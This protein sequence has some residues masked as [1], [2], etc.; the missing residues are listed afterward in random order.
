MFLRVAP[1][2]GERKRE[3]ERERERKKNGDDDDE[4]RRGEMISFPNL[5]MASRRTSRA[6]WIY[7]GGGISRHRHQLYRKSI[8]FFLLL[9]LLLLSSLFHYIA[10]EHI[11]GL[12]ISVRLTRF[13]LREHNSITNQTY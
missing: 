10:A 8:E 7:T 11:D 6:E 1:S 9:L 5:M 3:K 12:S 4:E 13:R 2:K